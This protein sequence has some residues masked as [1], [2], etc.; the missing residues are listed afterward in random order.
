MSISGQGLAGKEF[1][2]IKTFIATC[3]GGALLLKL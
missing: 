2:A 3:L 1:L